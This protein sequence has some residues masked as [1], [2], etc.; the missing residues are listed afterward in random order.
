MYRGN[1]IK[2][3]TID[4]PARVM[5][6]SSSPRKPQMPHILTGCYFYLGSYKIKMPRPIFSRWANGRAAGK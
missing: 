5:K 1:L 3:A 6:K 4:I 2:K